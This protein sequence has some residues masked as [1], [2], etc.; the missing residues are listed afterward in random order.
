ME[1][2]LQIGTWVGPHPNPTKNLPR[3]PTA[4]E[5]DKPQ[6]NAPIEESIKR[7]KATFEKFFISVLQEN[8]GNNFLNFLS[9]SNS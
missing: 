5:L 2:N 7:F 4:T 3:D 6:I 8:L 1:T 9:R